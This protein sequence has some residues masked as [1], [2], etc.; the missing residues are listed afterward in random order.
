MA[1]KLEDSGNYELFEDE[2]GHRF[3]ELNGERWYVWVEGQRSPLLVRTDSNHT[4]AHHILKGKFYLIDFNGD[5]KFRDVPHLFLQKGDVYQEFI[6]PNG[7]PT[8][9]DPQKRLVVTRK[10]L[11]AEELEPYVEQGERSAHH[12]AHH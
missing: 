9:D 5:P 12:G 8:D 11:P 4:K 2:H 6:V 3:L 1:A 7:L 10:T